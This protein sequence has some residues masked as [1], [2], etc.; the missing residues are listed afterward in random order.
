MAEDEQ[1]EPEPET[2]DDELEEVETSMTEEGEADETEAAEK[3]I[4]DS[5]GE[6]YGTGRRKEAVARV[7]IEAGSGNVTVNGT[8][9]EDYFNNRRKW[10][11]A[12]LEPLQCVGFEDDIDVRATTKGGGLTG[13]ADSL[14]LGIARAL[15]EMDDNARSWLRSAGHL[16]RDDREVERKKINQPGARAKQQVSKR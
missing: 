2:Q 6:F 15:V 12:V 1:A 4:V 11:N 3:P 9:P 8:A 16:T 10:I 14:K 13:Q 5:D 7:W